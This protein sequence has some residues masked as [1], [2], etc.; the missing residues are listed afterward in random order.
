MSGDWA[1]PA[2]VLGAVLA[3][4]E[5]LAVEDAIGVLTEALEQYTTKRNGAETMTDNMT[6][7]DI[8][9]SR[10][11]FT[12]PGTVFA[13][14]GPDGVLTSLTFTPAAADAGYFGPAAVYYDGP[15]AAA[16]GVDWAPDDTDGELW[17]GIQNHLAAGNEVKWEE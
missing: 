3:Q 11:T 7:R 5:D 16:D 13:T 10:T 17:H 12:I 2:H 6:A 8:V 15:E 1:D 9:R 4:V 14:I